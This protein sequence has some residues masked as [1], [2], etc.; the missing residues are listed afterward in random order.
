MMNCVSLLDCFCFLLMLKNNNCSLLGQINMNLEACILMMRRPASGCLSGPSNPAVY[1][2]PWPG[3]VSRVG[4]NT[5][6]EA[7]GEMAGWQLAT[8]WYP[9]LVLARVNSAW[10]SI[11]THTPSPYTLLPPCACHTFCWHSK[12]KW[13]TCAHEES[14]GRA[15]YIGLCCS[16]SEGYIMLPAFSSDSALKSKLTHPCKNTREYLSDVPWLIVT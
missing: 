8:G 4:R 5:G 6:R 3:T 7:A 14:K 12:Q 2:Q 15:V 13:K 16:H 1:V 9:Q 10:Q 11:S